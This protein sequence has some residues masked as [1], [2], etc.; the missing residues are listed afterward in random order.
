MAQFGEIMELEE[1]QTCQR[2]HSTRVGFEDLQSYLHDPH[3]MFVAK[4]LISQLL[5]LVNL[6]P[7]IWTI[8]VS[9]LGTVR[10]KKLF[11][12]KGF[13][14]WDFHYWNREAAGA[15][16]LLVGLLQLAVCDHPQCH[17]NSY[18]KSLELYFAAFHI[19]LRALSN[20]RA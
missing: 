19:F 5:T 4:D 8:R 15:G 3:L 18:R 16:V 14:P 13:W 7:Y 12:C 10:Q 1:V 2:K 20:V 9:P 17:L 6:L 11:L